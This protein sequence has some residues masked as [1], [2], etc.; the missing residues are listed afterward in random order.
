[1]KETMKIVIIK[2]YNYKGELD[3]I[4]EN[5]V[6]EDFYVKKQIYDFVFADIDVYFESHKNEGRKKHFKLKANKKIIKKCELKLE[7]T[8][9]A[10][11]IDYSIL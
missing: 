9:V 7:N 2:P 8:F 5:L 6:V 10:I 1:M 3:F 11:Q 4:I